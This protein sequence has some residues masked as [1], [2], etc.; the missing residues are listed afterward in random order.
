M[1]LWNRQCKVC[2]WASIVLLL[3]AGALVYIAIGSM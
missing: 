2:F 3:A 1:S